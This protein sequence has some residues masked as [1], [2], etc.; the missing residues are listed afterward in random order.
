MASKQES[1][2]D[3][4]E[5]A[6]AY[7]KAEKEIGTEPWVIVSIE[8]SKTKEKLYSYDLPRDMFWDKEWVI[9]WRVAKLQCQRPM[10]HIVYFLSF[11]DKKTG[12]EYGFNSLLSKLS[13]AKAQVTILENLMKERLEDGRLDLFFDET[14][15]PVVS[16]L[17]CKIAFQQDKIEKYQNEIKAK[18]GEKQNEITP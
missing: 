12:L 16:K 1:V 17:K 11:Y 15:D 6:K 13:S 3:W 8:D 5:L 9:R 4:M 7:A 14:T 18:V 2:G 10:N